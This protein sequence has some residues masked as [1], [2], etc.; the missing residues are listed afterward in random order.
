MSELVVIKCPSPL[1]SL[2]PEV[3]EAVITSGGVVVCPR[4][5]IL[6]NGE[7]CCDVVSS[8]IAVP[9]SRLR[10]AMSELGPTEVIDTPEFLKASL[11]L[12]TVPLCRLDAQL[13]RDKKEVRDAKSDS[14]KG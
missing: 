4:R 14:I 7:S 10:D 3:A 11:G 8:L 12:G 1:P 5:R 6:P 2:Y 9:L 13:R